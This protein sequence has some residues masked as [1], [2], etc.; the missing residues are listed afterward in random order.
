MPGDE[1]THV[2]T[3]FLVG[4]VRNAL[5]FRAREQMEL[6]TVQRG[7]IA[8]RRL[9]LYDDE[10]SHVKILDDASFRAPMRRGIERRPSYI[11]V[12]PIA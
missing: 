7:N 9:N 8:Y 3:Y 1:S 11:F 5:D 10:P 6:L 12:R 4:E 2:N